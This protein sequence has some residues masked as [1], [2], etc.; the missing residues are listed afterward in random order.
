MG[1]DIEIGT[2]AELVRDYRAVF[3]HIKDPLQIYEVAAY[4]E[5]KRY[6]VF[7][8]SRWHVGDD[9][10]KDV[11][12]VSSRYLKDNTA[13]CF[14]CCRDQM[15]NL[16]VD[17]RGKP[18][19]IVEPRVSA[20]RWVAARLGLPD[21]D[22]WRT[23]ILGGR[24]HTA[25]RAGNPDELEEQLDMALRKAKMRQK[26]LRRRDAELTVV[27]SS[28]AALEKKHS[29]TVGALC[30]VTD[31]R[32]VRANQVISLQAR[33]TQL[34]RLLADHGIESPSWREPPPWNP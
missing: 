22:A 21:R 6:L 5:G 24:L 15:F 11:V 9:E 3:K 8:V 23:A 10:D 1:A 31:D 20:G 33:V 2:Y 14:N 17:I 26:R 18:T 34:T 4:H 30:A 29:E 7:D 28:E 13:F 16:R 19:Y 27:K 25:I 12:P 32:R